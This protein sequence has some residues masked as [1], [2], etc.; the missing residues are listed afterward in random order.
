MSSLPPNGDSE[1]WPEAS[2]SHPC[3]ICKK[4]DWCQIAPD[5]NAAI[6]RR[7]EVGS[8]KRCGETGCLHRLKVPTHRPP[9]KKAKPVTPRDWPASAER[10]AK[11]LT[12]DDRAWLAH[13]LGLSVEALDAILLL[14]KCGANEFGIITTW[15]EMN[16]VGEVIG[17]TD[18]TPGELKDTEKMHSGGGNHVPRHTR[19]HEPS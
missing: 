14:G 12:R 8:A 18:R 3:P 4:P 17:I 10:F 5:G 16:A 1:K 15:P 2:A 7:T 9:A 11:Q 13:R 6:C 19:T